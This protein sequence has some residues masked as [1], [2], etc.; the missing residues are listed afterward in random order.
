M[1]L[2]YYIFTSNGKTFFS[3]VSIFYYESLKTNKNKVLWNQDVAKSTLPSYFFIL[4]ITLFYILIPIVD[5][6]E[7]FNA[8]IRLMLKL[9][10]NPSQL[11]CLVVVFHLFLSLL[12]LIF[13]AF[14]A[15]DYV[16][17]SFWFGGSFFLSKSLFHVR[18]HKA[19]CKSILF[20]SFLCHHKNSLFNNFLSILFMLALTLSYAN[21]STWLTHSNQIQ[22]MSSMKQTL[23]STHNSLV[24]FYKCTFYVK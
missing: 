21:L 18:C 7:S 14:K 19:I 11:N 12:R 5:I 4:R 10:R 23:S 15:I 1:Q 3:W 13:F 20:L 9:F 16:R 6:F 17:K 2:S 22:D 8:R 24:A